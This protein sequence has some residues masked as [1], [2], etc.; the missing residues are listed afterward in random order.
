MNWIK[1]FEAT[2]Y[3]TIVDRDTW[4]DLE[5]IE[6]TEAS[7]NVAD[8]DLRQS[9]EVGCVNYDQGEQW[10]RLWLDARQSGS[11]PE[12]VAMFTGIATSPTRT[13]NGVLRKDKLECYSVLKP[14][15][16]IPLQ[17]GWYAPK[18]RDGTQIIKELLKVTPAPVI[19][20]EGSSG[21][22]SQSIIAEN[23][24]SHLT[25]VGKILKAIN[26]RIWIE[27]DGTVHVSPKAD[28]IVASFDPLENDAV[29]TT[30]DI[31]NDLYKCPNV[32]QAFIGDASAIARD[33]SDSPISIP[34]RRREVWKTEDNCDLNDGETLLQYAQRRLKEEQT[35][36]VQVSYN[37][38]FVPNVS[39]GDY[40]R[41]HYPEQ[42]V[43]G[44]F[45]VK[46]QS[47]NL[48][49]GA[50]VSETSEKVSDVVSY[51]HRL[52]DSNWKEAREYDTLVDELGNE[53]IDEFTNTLSE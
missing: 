29:Q 4:K 45:V 53:L 44:M 47:F 36:A 25:M 5:R 24:E 10:I 13:I 17:R 32:F 20:D 8:S 37:R 31:S 6:I 16:E 28:S 14:A 52:E 23:N 35:V 42:G 43:D 33:E 15:E 18:G 2:Y 34:S 38:R 22:L 11:Q 26:R 50:Q 41:L 19:I 3:M 48:E 1:G 40:I 27:G 12:H 51:L 7:V 46:S 39:V 21:I 9:A 30:L 49:Y